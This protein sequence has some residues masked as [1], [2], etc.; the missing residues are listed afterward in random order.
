MADENQSDSVLLKHA[1][2]CEK[3]APEVLPFKGEL[4]TRISTNLETLETKINQLESDSS[5][6]L[7]RTMYQ[8][9]HSRVL[10]MLRSY[11]RVRTMKIEKFVMSILDDDDMV[12]NISEAEK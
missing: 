12:A 8:Y 5:Y 3:A 1:L 7:M 11:H 2:M 4:V 6:E 9:E 10:Y